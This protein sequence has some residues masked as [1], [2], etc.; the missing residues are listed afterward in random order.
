M[1]NRAT[2]VKKKKF[3]RTPGGKTVVHYSRHERANAECAVTGEKLQGTGDQQKSRVRK[4][5]KTM[6]RPSV[7]FGG[8]LS[9]RPRREVWEN[10]ALIVSGRK[11]VEEVPAKIRPYVKSQ[12]KKVAGE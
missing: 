11:S 2:R 1:V 7:K 9:T 8:V 12:L 5:P 6:K 4:L 3:R 10:Y